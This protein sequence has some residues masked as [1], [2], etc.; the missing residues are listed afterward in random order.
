MLDVSRGNVVGD[1]CQ[2][3]NRDPRPN[4]PFAVPHGDKRLFPF[5][6]LSLLRVTLVIAT[7]ID[8]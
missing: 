2:P 7:M 4:P 8:E 5:F 3:R 6:L 1:R